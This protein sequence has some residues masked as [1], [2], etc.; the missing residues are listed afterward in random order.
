VTNA[1]VGGRSYGD[2]MVA[3]VT[4]EQVLGFRVR[5]QQLDRD[6]TAV[7]DADALNMGVQDTGPDGALWA[8]AI[9]GVDVSALTDRD[10]V[11]LWTIRGAPHVYRR[12]DLASVAA[13][14]AP[15]SEVDAGK[16]I[17][18]AAKPL[19]AAGISNLAAL[20]VVASTMRS[21]V[22]QPMA[23]G[24]VSGQLSTVLDEPYLRWCRACNATHIYEM[25]FRLA[26]VRAGL[27][28][29]ADT[30][31]PVLEPF[32][33]V[34]PAARAAQQHNTIRAYL[35]LLGP[36]TPKHVAGY[37]DAPVKDVTT[38][39]PDDVV[40][41]SVQ[42]DQRWLLADDADALAAGVAKATRLLGPF[43]LFLQAKD[44]PLLVDDQARSKALWPVLGRPG[45]VLVDGE[46]AGMWRPR[47]SGKSLKLLVELWRKP[48]P[49]LRKAIGTQ[50]ERLAAHRGVA[51]SDVD[52]DS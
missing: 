4:R 29:R 25:P 26:A 12:K 30:S 23:K 14:V 10:L 8:L 1:V 51:L 19:K 39:W 15:F 2:R 24:D 11:K 18:D 36:A 3:S 33:R 32:G 16:R 45:A 46:V 52:F 21:L 7:A 17:F 5:A 41:V 22:A 28:L 27:E 37:L 35:R 47:K 34:R 38:R 20:D 50:A 48:T 13:A 6:S 42:G 43:D 49:T 31:P 44:R 9:R 40:E